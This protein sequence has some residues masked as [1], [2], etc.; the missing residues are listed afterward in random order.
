MNRELPKGV[1]LRG[2]KLWISFTNKGEQVRKSTGLD[3]S[4]KNS[5]RAELMLERIRDEI[6]IGGFS[7]RPRPSKA[8]LFREYASEWFER[9]S[10]ARRWAPST[11]APLKSRMER[12]IIPFFGDLSMGQIDELT[13]KRFLGTL[14]HLSP[15]AL[16]HII[17]PLKQIFSEAHRVGII[18]SDP[19]LGIK[20]LRVKKSD[21]KPFTPAEISVLL[22][23]CGPE[24]RP[25]VTTAFYTAMSPHELFGL[26]WE[27]VDFNRN[28]IEVREGRVL[29]KT[30]PL[31]NEHR[32]RDV[33]M[34]SI[35][36]GVLKEHRAASLLKSDYVFCNNYGQPLDADGFREGP[37]KRLLKKAGFAYRGFVQTRHTAI[38][39]MLAS[40]EN[41]EWVARVAGH[42]DT[43]MIIR[44]YSRYAPNLM[45][46][47]DGDAFE[48]ALSGEKE[49][50]RDAVI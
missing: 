30:S 8:G 34:P 7:M 11:I 21:I 35:V 10:R 6:A 47:P 5:R 1:H 39:V 23:A 18:D 40:G 13:I 2:R 28:V 41:P 31:K 26:K 20:K 48:R 15:R 12:Y 22:K 9:E 44:V 14:E 46:R 50:V 32:E 43:A 19:A 42:R 49:E 38:T 25:L 33:P 4:E 16:N 37:W 3:D 24:I 29:G 27:R 45:G 36:S 17:D